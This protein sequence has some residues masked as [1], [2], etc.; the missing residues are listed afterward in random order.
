MLNPK[1]LLAVSVIAIVADQ[2]SAAAQRELHAACSRP[3][4]L[5]LEEEHVAKAQRAIAQ[6][7]A[8]AQDCR[9]R[10]ARAASTSSS[11]TDRTS[12]GT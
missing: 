12:A 4:L 3:Q 6:V 1:T 11:T 7:D 8:A 5:S 2:I 10:R 9:G